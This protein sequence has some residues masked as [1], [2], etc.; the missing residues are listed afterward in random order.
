MATPAPTP[1]IKV[2][3][4]PPEIAAKK[5][6]DRASGARDYFLFGVRNPKRS[7][8]EAAI[9]MRTTL[10]QKMAR[11]EVWDRWE[12]RR[13]AAGDALWLA[14]IELLGADRYPRGVEIG[15]ALWYD[16][17]TKFDDKLNEVLGKV[18][19]IPRVTIDDSVRRVEALI[20]GLYGWRYKPSTMS[21]ENI[22][23]TVDKLRAIRL[24]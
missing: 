22:R 5:F 14:K 1:A 7:P 19:S 10:E 24:A 16:F 4:K 20:R 6:L 17:Y 15:A 3:V 2:S 21:T 11:K 8:T 9:S 18:Y 12:E 23:S 13:R